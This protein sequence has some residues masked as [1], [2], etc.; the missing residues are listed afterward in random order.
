MGTREENFFTKR[1][2]K[3]K[4]LKSK[5]PYFLL[6]QEQKKNLTDYKMSLN[7]LYYHYK[8]SL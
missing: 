7:T 5:R 8:M 4:A 3:F 2:N 1:L 6:L